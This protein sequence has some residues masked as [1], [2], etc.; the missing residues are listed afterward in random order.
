MKVDVFIFVEG[1]MFEDEIFV[2]CG[3]IFFFDEVIGN[4]DVFCEVI[5]IVCFCINELKF[6]VYQVDE[7]VDWVS[8]VL[9]EGILWWNVGCKYCVF[10]V[11]MCVNKGYKFMERVF[12]FEGGLDGRNWFKYVVFVFGL[13][14]GYVGG[15][16]YFKFFFDFL[17]CLYN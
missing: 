3:S 13:W 11:I 7:F 2:L 9:E 8:E 17:L 10:K 5:K 6:K 15:K 12:F 1:K 14:M 16:W 4:I